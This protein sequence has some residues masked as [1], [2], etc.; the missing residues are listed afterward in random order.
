MLYSYGDSFALYISGKT[1]HREACWEWIKFLTAQPEAISLLPARTDVLATQTWW[2]RVGRET[3]EA[4]QA[5]LAHQAAIES[6]GNPP[7]PIDYR[8]PHWLRDALADVL[9]GTNPEA[10]LQE[11]QKKA[12]VYV[13]CRRAAEE[14]G[15]GKPWQECA[16]EADPDVVLPEE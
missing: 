13:E 15:S 14:S 16:R 9:E 5:E 8:V 7:S 11:A 12:M 1:P 4:A 6:L 10:A 2:N 3:A